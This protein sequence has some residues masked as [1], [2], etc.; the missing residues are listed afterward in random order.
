[1]S[2]TEISRERNTQFPERW[3]CKYGSTVA[4]GSSQELPP[5]SEVSS[6][7][8]NSLSFACPESKSLQAI[9]RKDLALK[10]I[11]ILCDSL[12]KSQI[13]AFP[14]TAKSSLGCELIFW[15]S[16]NWASEAIPLEDKQP[17]MEDRRFQSQISRFIKSIFISVGSQQLQKSARAGENSKHTL[18]GLMGST[19]AGN[20]YFKIKEF[21]LQI[22]EN[23]T[24]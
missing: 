3:Q 18:H 10:E 5:W 19:P 16:I 6:R 9:W 17:F 13:P 11:Y 20:Q 7:K 23:L 2:P 1:M 12:F 24:S 14:L 8:R 21:R 22:K 4:S 15:M